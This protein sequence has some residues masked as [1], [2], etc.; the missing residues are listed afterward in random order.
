MFLESE[1]VIGID[2]NG[3]GVIILPGINVRR[4]G[5]PNAYPDSRLVRNVYSGNTSLVARVFLSC[6]S[7]TSI[8]EIVEKINARNG[9]ITQPTVSKALKQLQEDLIISKEK[10][11]IRLIQP[12][13]L[14]ERLSSEFSMPKV[15]QEIK[16]AIA[17]PTGRALYEAANRIGAKIALTGSSAANFIVGDSVSSFYCNAPL[18]KLINALKEPPDLNSRFPNVRLIETED[19]TAY[20]DPQYN[21]TDGVLASS[22]VQTWLELSAGDGRQKDAASKYR[23]LILER[24]E[25]Y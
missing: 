20:F 18:S 24:L 11:N 23:Q 25:P 4:A 12:E 5:Q 8:N 3:N 2:L 6:P 14:L 13:K 15:I 19:P 17:P 16:F 21:E 10:Q 9:E 1:L 7:F 22:P